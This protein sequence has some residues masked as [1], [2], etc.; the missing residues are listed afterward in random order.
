MFGKL[1][2]LILSSSLSEFTHFVSFFKNSNHSFELI[3]R[4]PFDWR[5]PIGYIVGYTLQFGAMYFLLNYNVGQVTVPMGACNLLIAFI[6]DAKE[7]LASLEKANKNGGTLS[8]LKKEAN[9]FISLHISLK[10]LSF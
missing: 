10:Q 6:N 2:L 1:L 9:E 8:D 3:I 7:K 5:T 4:Y